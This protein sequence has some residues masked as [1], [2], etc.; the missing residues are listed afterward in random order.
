MK[1]NLNCDKL[2]FPRWQNYKA[3]N[4][5]KSANEANEYLGGVLLSGNFLEWRKT[6][7]KIR[8]KKLPKIRRESAVEFI[9]A[10]VSFYLSFL[11]CMNR[12][13]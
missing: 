9:E 13:S 10:R 4:G 1:S 3:N 6:E 5:E 8:E 7:W 2:D 12:R 11:K